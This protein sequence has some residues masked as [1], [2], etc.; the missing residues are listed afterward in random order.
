MVWVGIQGN[1]GHPHLEGGGFALNKGQ[2]KTVKAP[3]N[4]QGRIWPRTWCDPKTKHC[5]TGDC[6]NKLQCNGAGG[7]PPATLAEITLKGAHGLDNYDISLVDGFNIPMAMWPVGGKSDGT[8]YSC[9]RASCDNNLNFSCPSNLRMNS[10]HGVIACK[11]ACL[12]YNTDAY[13]CK[14]IYNDSKKCKASQYA[15]YFKSHCPMAYSYA[16]NDDKALMTCTGV[17]KYMITFM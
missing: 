12:A 1:P 2:T 8:K 5:L 4:W 10:K 17:Q 11:S 9:K 14:G 15:N 16:Y 6:G 13:C 7:V 3:G